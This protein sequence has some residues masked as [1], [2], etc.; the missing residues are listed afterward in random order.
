MGRALVHGV[1]VA[2]IVVWAVA[3]PDLSDRPD[4][5]WLVEVCAEFDVC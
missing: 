2:L 4:P 1:F 5:E 3:A